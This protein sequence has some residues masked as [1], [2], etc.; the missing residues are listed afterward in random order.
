MATLIFPTRP[1]RRGGVCVGTP[2]RAESCRCEPSPWPI[3][4]DTCLRCG[5]HPEHIV[6]QTWADRARLLAR[7]A[8]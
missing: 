7:K 1:G 3:I 5:R 2:E 8:A 4:D 6:S